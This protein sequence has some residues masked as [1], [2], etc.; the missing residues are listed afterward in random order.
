M[1]SLLG[2]LVWLWDALISNTATA[3]NATQLHAADLEIGRQLSR[4]VEDQARAWN[5]GDIDQFMQAYWNS[6]QLTF[7]SG[8]KTERGW[9]ATRERYRTRYPD[10]QTMGKLIFSRLEVTPLSDS[11]AIMLGQWQLI[12]SEPVQGNFT[13]VWRKIDGT[14]LIVHDHTSVLTN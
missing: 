11:A 9:K 8:G 4:I 2:T 3:Q 13:L 12:R 1:C 14:W 6:E 7:S 5:D 10:R